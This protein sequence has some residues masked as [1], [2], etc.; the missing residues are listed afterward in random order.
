MV[1]KR[2]SPDI[3]F[4][5]SLIC[6]SFKMEGFC[7]TLV[8]WWLVIDRLWTSLS[9]SEPP[10]NHHI[11][12][13]NTMTLAADT[14]ITKLQSAND[15]QLLCHVGYKLKISILVKD[16]HDFFQGCHRHQPT[17]KKHDFWSSY[18]GLRW[19][20]IYPANSKYCYLIGW[21]ELDP[22]WSS[23]YLLFLEYLKV[24]FQSLPLP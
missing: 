22:N 6:N 4:Q 9:Q 23:Y 7:C 3:K 12:V 14:L 24:D 17:G 20:N 10:I 15:W 19:E 1:L 11:W 2:L 18:D 13:E 21:V 16:D 5:S 8:G